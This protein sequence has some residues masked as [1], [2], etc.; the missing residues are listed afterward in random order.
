MATAVKVP[1]V[2]ESITEVTIA[3]WV[4]QNGDMVR[5]DEVIAELESEKATFE[6]TAPAA[7]RLVVHKQKGD[8]VPIGEVVC[9]IDESAAGKSESPK[10][11]PAA[12]PAPAAGSG[13]GKPTGAVKEM[14]VPAVGL[15]LIHI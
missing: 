3:N 8:A 12:A 5:M 6:L 2:G 10:P 15:S 13:S 9:E 7:G 4:R 14:K 11:A 1:P